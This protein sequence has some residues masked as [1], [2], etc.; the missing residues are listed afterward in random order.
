MKDEPVKITLM[1]PPEKVADW[2]GCFVQ[3]RREIRNGYM[4]FPAGSV[5]KIT[6][7]GRVKHLR[8]EMCPCCG[9]QPILS[10]RA[11]RVDFL[12]DF[13]FVQ[14]RETP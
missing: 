1:T 14:K 2:K 6:A 9:V 11:H 8:G 10:Y 5:M 12:D 13:N 3:L 7:S 4:V